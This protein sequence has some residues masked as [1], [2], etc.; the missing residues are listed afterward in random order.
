MKP[1][2]ILT[3]ILFFVGLFF[4]KLDQYFQ[5]LPVLSG[6]INFMVLGLDYRNDQLEKTQTTDTIIFASYNLK[7]NKITII[8]LPR[9]IWDWQL[10]SKIN[11]IYPRS[12][13]QPNKFKYIKDNF[14]R[15]TGQKID[16]VIIINTDT[17][18]SLVKLVGGI[19]I[20]LETGFK[21]TQYPNPEHVKN[22][23][24]KNVP[25]YITVEF[26]PG[27][28]HLDSNNILPFVRSRKSLIGGTDIGR[29]LRQQLVIEA[30]LQ[31]IK[32]KSFY[33]QSK[34]IINLY[35]FWHRQ[36]IT[37]VTDNSLLSL[38]LQQKTKLLQA[39]LNKIDIPPSL[40]YHPNKF[41]NQQWVFIFQDKDF[42]LLHQFI[43]HSL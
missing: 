14:Q 9:D 22:P 30:I 25:V 3:L 11:D 13:E 42:T 21:D 23:L 34:N 18:A 16:H 43:A 29:I 5:K 40:Y 20:S 39:S 35:Q 7:S 33:T 12:L 32:S 36:I 19:D 2:A 1:K 38:L 17:L 37:D 10:G 27:L 15:I 24:D 28:V 41:I 26:K 6:Q 31:K 4:L 8:S